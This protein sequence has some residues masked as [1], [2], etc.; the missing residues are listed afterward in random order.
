VVSVALTVVMVQRY[1]QTGKVMPGGA[2]AA[3]SAAMALFYLWNLLLF[4]PKLA[5]KQH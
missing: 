1:Q 4:R 5:A 3:L 2:V